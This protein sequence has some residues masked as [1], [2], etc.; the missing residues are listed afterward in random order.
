MIDPRERE[1]FD[2][3]V[4]LPAAD[5]VSFLTD[6]CEGDPGLQDRMRKL[7]QGHDRES[8][9]TDTTGVGS[10]PAATNPEK[11]GPYYLLKRIGEGGMGTVYAAD[12][13]SPIHRRVALKVIKPGMDTQ[14]VIARFEAE[15]QALALMSHPNIAAILDAGTTD[16]G[17]PYFVMEYVA[18]KPLSEYCDQHHLDLRERLNLFL[19]VCEAVQHAHQK[20]IIHRDLKPSNLLVTVEGELTLPKVIDF[21]IAKAVTPMPGPAHE[22]KIGVVIGTPTYMSP[23]Q[24]DYTMDVD[25]RA[26]VYAL[27]MVLYEL[28][29][30]DLPF[31]ESDFHHLGF[32][33]IRRHLHEE[34]FVRPSARVRPGSG[35]GEYRASCRQLDGVGHR[36][37]LKGDL[38][39]IVMKALKKDRAGRYGSAVELADD[40]RRHLTGQAVRAGPDRVSYRAKKFVAR[41]RTSVAIVGLIVVLLIGGIVASLWQA[42]VARRERD[43]AAVAQA[44]AEDAM[45][46]MVRT[47]AGGDV[48]LDDSV[49]VRALFARGV[50]AAADTLIGPLGRARRF[51]TMG[52]IYLGLG[53]WFAADSMLQSAVNLFRTAYPEGHPEL[54][55]SLRSLGHARRRERLIEETAPL[56]HEA[57]AILMEWYGTQHE[58][59][60]RTYTELSKHAQGVGDWK[61]VEA[62]QRQAILSWPSTHTIGPDSIAFGLIRMGEIKSFMGD[63]RAADSLYRKAIAEQERAFGPHHPTPAYSSL[64][65]GD[66]YVM[67]SQPERAEEIFRRALVR[68]EAAWGD[69]N[70]SLLFVWN[71]LADALAA[72]G[73][74]DDA[75]KFK[76]KGLELTRRQRGPNAIYLQALQVAATLA[77]AGRYEESDSLFRLGTAFLERTYGPNA[78]NTRSKK[79]AYVDMLVK[80]NRMEEAESLLVPL[81]SFGVE[82][83][84]TT[85]RVA[86]THYQL[87]RIFVS[88]GDFEAGEHHLHAAAD[89]IDQ[90]LQERT[91]LPTHVDVQVIYRELIDLYETW[92]LPDSADRYRQVLQDPEV[93]FRAEMRP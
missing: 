49:T 83:T 84:P 34:E 55:R 27:G 58:D 46:F 52:L 38:D 60:A 71:S 22:T 8:V 30:G 85:R 64:Y 2:R 9:L 93:A 15:R 54:A 3:L 80:A 16:Q 41:H 62:Y 57:L 40:L 21:G 26:D 32:E 77:T 81:L 59:I 36:K 47:F 17:R 42:N 82:H 25:T 76:L 39:A 90:R 24:A 19:Q 70:L 5:R 89:I 37:R 33:E 56:Y 7:L 23:E 12:Q 73:Q 78:E 14:E 44:S 91:L 18:G 79:L 31:D 69:D 63:Y 67:L 29:T 1:L 92:G 10:S 66:L 50:S 45:E 43:L 86:L 72:Q 74:Y 6:A 88:R 35:A 48:A 53:Q 20:G 75:I 65:L 51:H 13:R 4:A 61:A 28:L 11:I 87:G 68:L